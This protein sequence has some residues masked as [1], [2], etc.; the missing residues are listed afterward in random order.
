VNPSP[1]GETSYAF[2]QCA[3]TVG[4]S[5]NTILLVEL[6]EPVAI[7][8]AV[9]TVDEV[10]ERK[11]IGSLHSGSMIFALRSG[12][13]RFLWLDGNDDELRRLLGRE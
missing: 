9:I 4:G 11:R 2:V 8:K 12:A 5:L 13:M 7:D 6:T 1:E 10:L 3:D